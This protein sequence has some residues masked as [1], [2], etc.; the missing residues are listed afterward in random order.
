M[1]MSLL[2]E[3]SLYGP[4]SCYRRLPYLQSSVIL[5][6]ILNPN[7]S[8]PLFG[9]VMAVG[10]S[11]TCQAMSLGPSVSSTG[12]YPYKGYFESHQCL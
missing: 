10:N 9:T 4:C 1:S 2:S 5:A 7:A 11:Y 8:E 12:S 3:L 6:L